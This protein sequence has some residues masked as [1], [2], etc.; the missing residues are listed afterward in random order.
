MD[1][2]K[3]TTGGSSGI[4][5]SKRWKPE[6][7]SIIKIPTLS[8]IHVFLLK[9]NICFIFLLYPLFPSKLYQDRTAPT[10]ECRGCSINMIFGYR[11]FF[12]IK[13]SVFLGKYIYKTCKLQR[14]HFTFGRLARLR[15]NSSSNPGI[16]SFSFPLRYCS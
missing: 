11:N 3:D 1:F 8:I 2:E 12:Y 5:V 4:F 15:F 13:T 16:S 7:F 14:Y 6:R 10:F 9:S